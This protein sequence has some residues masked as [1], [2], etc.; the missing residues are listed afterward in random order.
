MRQL[1][2]DLGSEG[3]SGVPM[4]LTGELQEQLV[5]LMAEA[6]LA[7]LLDDPRRAARGVGEDGDE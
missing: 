4:Q 6:L 2:L 3:V 7:L 1:A 5:V